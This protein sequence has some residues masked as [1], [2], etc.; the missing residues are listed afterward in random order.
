MVQTMELIIN[1]SYI[2]TFMD[3]L[4]NPQILEINTIYVIRGVF[5]LLY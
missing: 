1:S 3:R 4:G 2:I 5:K